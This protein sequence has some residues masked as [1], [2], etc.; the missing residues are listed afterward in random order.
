MTETDRQRMVV[1]GIIAAGL[2]AF[3]AMR[4]IEIGWPAFI[5]IGTVLMLI[6]LAMACFA[7][8]VGRDA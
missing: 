5:L 1:S 7:L 3:A 2:G 6:G 8:I 4:S